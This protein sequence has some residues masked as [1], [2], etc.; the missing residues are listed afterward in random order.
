MEREKTERALTEKINAG[1]ILSFKDME[2]SIVCF[3]T[4][5]SKLVGR[6]RS[7]SLSRVVLYPNIFFGSSLLLSAVGMFYYPSNLGL[8][9]ASEIILISAGLI[10][11]SRALMGVQKVSQG[12]EGEE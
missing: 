2:E 6:L 11:F 12:L 7:I 1:E 5:E 8:L 4:K 9:Y 10:I 3:K